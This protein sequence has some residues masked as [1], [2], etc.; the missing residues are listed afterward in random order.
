VLHAVIMAGGVGTRFWPLSRSRSPKQLLRF[1]D[2][3][4]MVQKTVARLDSLIPPERIVV[5]T[6][7]VQEKSIRDHLPSIPSANILVEPVGKNTA[8]CI[9]L[10]AIH[11]LRRDP[12]AVMTVLAAD[13]LI[14]PAVDFCRTLDFGAKVAAEK[15]V[16]V[17]MGIPPTRA[18]TG[19]GYVQFIDNDRIGSGDLVA[20]RVKTFAEKPN[21]ETAKRFLQSGDFLWNSGMFIWRVSTILSLMEEYLPE[22]HEGLGEIASAIGKRDYARELDRVYRGFRSI[23]IDYGVMERAKDV[24][25]IRAPF[26]WNDVG[27]WEEVYQLTKKDEQANA[28]RG[29]VVLHDVQRSLI[30][31][32]KKVVAAIGVTDL[33]IVETEDALL[34][35][36]RDQAQDVKKIVDQLVA[37]G[38]DDLL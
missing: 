35:C 21:E 12:D 19:Y 37:N 20:H 14:E 28:V 31:S 3:Q 33:I 18:E 6:N 9:G 2:E 11:I 25:V 26:T 38:K 34:V 17:T 4:S 23:S 8:P 16:L 10:A 29:D 15:N 5:V 27:S 36:R 32:H 22:L 1:F 7:A 30:F 13:H 24:Y